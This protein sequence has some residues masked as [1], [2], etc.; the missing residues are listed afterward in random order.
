MINLEISIDQTDV[1]H[2]TD[3]GKMKQFISHLEQ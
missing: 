2:R 3:A 1:I